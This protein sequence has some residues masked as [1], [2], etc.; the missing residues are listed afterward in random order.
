MDSVHTADR[1][2]GTPWHLWAVGILALLFT[3]FG[4]YD[5]YMTQIGDREY[6]AAAM[7][8]VGVDADTAL[9]Y[10]ENFPIWMHAVWAIG[11]W[12]GL[13]GAVLVLLRS[14]FAYPVFAVSL[15]AFVISN[16]YGVF[17]P[18][19][20]MESGAAMYGMVAVVFVVLLALVFYTRAMARRGVLR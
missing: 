12:G 5:Y 4:C 2:T 10:F 13:A 9:R 16:A 14:R 1:R 19:P 18:I 20:G 3:A 15:V 8:P 17:N 11:V 7:E 6:I